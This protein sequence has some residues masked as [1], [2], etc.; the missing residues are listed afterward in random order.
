MWLKPSLEPRQVMISLSGIEPRAVALEIFG[1]HFAA[2]VDDTGR[3]G[4]AVAVG[5]ARR[6]GQLVDD[7]V[8]WRVRGDYPSPS[9]SRRPRPPAFHTSSG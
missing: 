5:I 1:R 6:F 8:M 3:L 7:R 9:R 4:V 2:Q